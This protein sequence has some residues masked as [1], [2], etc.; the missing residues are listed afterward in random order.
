MTLVYRRVFPDYETFRGSA[1]EITNTFETSRIPLLQTSNLAKQTAEKVAEKLES[2]GYRL[3]E[4][5]VYKDELADRDRWV[6]KAYAYKAVHSLV[7]LSTVVAVVVGVLG[8]IFSLWLISQITSDVKEIAWGAGKLGKE[9]LET[10]GWAIGIGIVA[11][12]VGYVLQKLREYKAPYTAPVVAG[13]KEVG[14]K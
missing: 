3:L 4:V 2:E 11:F 7:A 12:S 14:E 6:V 13:I 9:T 8:A 1:V 5:K 10:I